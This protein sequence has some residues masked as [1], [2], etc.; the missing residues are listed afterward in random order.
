MTDRTQESLPAQTATGP[1]TFD[2]PSSGREGARRIYDKCQRQSQDQSHRRPGDNSHVGGKPRKDQLSREAMRFGWLVSQL[3][4]DGI[5]QSEMAR[6]MTDAGRHYGTIDAT[7]I[8]KIKNAGV[9]GIGKGIG[10]DIIR[11]VKDGLKVDPAYFYDD[12]DGQKPY[13]L[14]SISAK[15]D[16]KRVTAIESELAELKKQLADNLAETQRLHRSIAQLV[17]R[18]DGRAAVVTPRK[19]P[20]APR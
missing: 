17:E 16:E 14:Y 3:E 2:M 1:W 5:S 6:R 10:A 12:Y 18:D 20:R 15:R 7:Y 13:Q 8:N 9:K 19:R 11:M 4:R